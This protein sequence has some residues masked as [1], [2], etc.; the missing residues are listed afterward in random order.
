MVL[1]V[2]L[3]IVMTV[4]APTSRPATQPTGIRVNASDRNAPKFRTIKRL[5]LKPD[6]PAHVKAWF[7][8]L[9]ELKAEELAM[10]QDAIDA[11]QQEITSTKVKIDT[12]TKAPL[13]TISGGTDN[14]GTPIRRRDEAAIAARMDEIK[15]LRLL[16]PQLIKK[17]RQ[18]EEDRRTCE[19]DQAYFRLPRW[20]PDRPQRLGIIVNL[21]VS[22]LVEDGTAIVKCA[23]KDFWLLG[24]NTQGWSDDT[25]QTLAEIV[26]SLRKQS[27]TTVMGA[28]RTLAV[29]EPTSVSKYVD[30]VEEQVLVP[31][32]NAT[33]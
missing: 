18:Q 3:A 6:A 7:L 26:V 25:D 5:I 13:P 33:P 1:H 27:Y 10:R 31:N 9:P 29:I 23:G 12:L 15:S 19:E 16:I 2:L 20:D 21:R 4:Q 11:T 24:V 22:Q 32:S 8:S 30:S 14:M 17:K 28:R